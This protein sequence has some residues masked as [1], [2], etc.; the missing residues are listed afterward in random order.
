MISGFPES[1]RFSL[2]HSRACRARVLR[3]FLT[4]WTPGDRNEVLRFADPVPA[5]RENIDWLR[6]R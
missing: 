5:L 6:R 3:D 2:L 1:W 4:L